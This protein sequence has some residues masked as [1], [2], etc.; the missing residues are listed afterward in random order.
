MNARGHKG[1]N[2]AVWGGR[3]NAHAPRGGG[4]APAPPA[5][6][7]GALL[8]APLNA[9]GRRPPPRRP[10]GLVADHVAPE[11]D[12]PAAQWARAAPAR[13]ARR[14]RVAP[15]P[16]PTAE[17]ALQRML[18]GSKGGAS[19]AAPQAAPPGQAQRGRSPPYDA[20]RQA[21]APPPYEAGDLGDYG[22]YADDEAP[23]PP[24]YGS[25]PPPPPSSYGDAY[26]GPPGWQPPAPAQPHRGA[27]PPRSAYAGEYGVPP[28]WEASAVP[29]QSSRYGSSR[30]AYSPRPEHTDSSLLELYAITMQSPREQGKSRL[31]AANEAARAAPRIVERS[32]FDQQRGSFDQP[33]RE[34]N[35]YPPQTAPTR[36]AAEAYW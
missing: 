17:D 29:T 12:D 24:P 16:G 4:R 34:W 7:A 31:A 30:S 14:D 13:P 1:F 33:G 26:G 23:P 25:A 9:A 2:A 28:R 35:P 36:G 27:Q 18:A 32:S 5:A 22:A 21:P 11:N 19:K 3:S 8:S 20:R 6:S 10:D 15:V